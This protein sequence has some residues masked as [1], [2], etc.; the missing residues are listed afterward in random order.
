MNGRAT[1]KK[2]DDRSHRCYFMVYTATTGLIFYLKLDHPFVI[3][4]AHHV[5]FYEFNSLISIEDN[6]TTGSLLLWKDPEGNFHESD[7]IKFIPYELDLTYTPFSDTT[8]ITY[9]I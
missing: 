9:E 6:H 5:Y 7:L 4:R 2:L 1:I 3:H 8:T